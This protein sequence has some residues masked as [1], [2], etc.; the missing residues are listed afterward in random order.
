M[1]GV[2]AVG[3]AEKQR[4]T[5]QRAEELP[6]AVERLRQIQASLG[7]GGFTQHGGIG[8]GGGFQAAQAAGDH[9]QREEEKLEA[10]RCS[11]GHKQQGA[12]GIE[13]QAQQDAGLVAVPVHQQAGGQGDQEISAEVGAL[14]QA[15]LR[16]ADVQG[17]LEVL[18][19]YIEQAIGQAPEKEQAGD[20]DQCPAIG[21]NR[22]GK[23]RRCDVRVL[24]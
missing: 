13:A 16:L 18:V 15:R 12:G 6:Q 1:C 7:S 4:T 3:A 10:L 22:P 20:Q 11:G 5:N 14:Q 24:E 23:G 21:R 17:F 9:K 19:E 2:G 8:V